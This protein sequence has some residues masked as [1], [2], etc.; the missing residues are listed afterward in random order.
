MRAHGQPGATVSVG[1]HDRVDEWCTRLGGCAQ[2][3]KRGPFAGSYTRAIDICM[4]GREWVVVHA[5]APARR[6]ALGYPPCFARVACAVGI[7]NEMQ[8]LD[9]Y[10]DGSSSET[11]YAQD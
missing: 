7:N 1:C 3:C 6:P 5:S 2:S 11:D 9:G 4:R 8:R 10:P